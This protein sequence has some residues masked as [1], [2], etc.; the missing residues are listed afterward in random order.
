MDVGLQMAFPSHGW[1]GVSDTQV[2]DEEIRLARLADD[3]GFDVLWAVEHHFFDYS[4]CPDNLQLMAY[5]AGVTSHAD[6]GTAAVILPWNDPLRV[7]ERVAQLDYLAKGKLR[8]G[9]GRGLSR[10][11]YAC[12]G[13]VRMDQSRE[14][15][16]E[17]APMILNAL[18]TGFIEGAGPFYPQPRA[19]IRPKP[20]RSFA[21]RL[22][23]VASSADSIESAARVEARMVMFADRSW[24]QR[25]P[26]IQQH[27]DL[28]MRLHGKA[29]PPP[30][31]CDYCVCTP[32]ES[33][34]H[35]LAH[36]HMAIYLDSVLEHYEV[37]GDHF[38]D[39][40]G[41]DA[42]AKASVVLNKIGAPGF[43]DGFMR[44][45]TWGTPDKI[46]RALE[47]R[48]E[49]LGGYELCT[50]FRFGG[51]PFAEAEA[52]MRLFASEVMPT[53]KTWTA[54]AARALE[55]VG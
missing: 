6:V 17:A 34:A 21:E 30:L 50:T 13:D 43:L 48:R 19:P 52:S 4:F 16:D 37:M 53:L 39:T 20:E 32:T 11:E 25:L 35:E 51:I 18:R 45:S 5:L 23:A 1:E 29:A 38:K 7:A 47:A 49:L 44:A 31:T 42:Y 28:F 14:R 22:Y 15:F 10:R 54:P 3:L 2:Y 46:L 55:T 40:K 9:I 12:F 36:R 33:Q 24:E 41:Y 27:R 26:S 8:L